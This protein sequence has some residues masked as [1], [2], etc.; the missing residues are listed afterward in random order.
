[1]ITMSARQ[2]TVTPSPRTRSAITNRSRIH[3]NGDERSAGARRFRDLVAAFS[4]DLGD[5]LSEADMAMIRTAA[6][7]TLKSE[8]MQAALIAGQAI[9]SDVLIRL[10]STSRRA[11]AAV[12]A[13][14]INRQ[15]GG[16]TLQD[17]LARRAAPD[18]G[19]E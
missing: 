5:N 3:Q 2:P 9:D 6:A 12:S 11:L 19:E 16:A 15:P 7:L 13:K 4:A 14:A 17:Y 10:A 18:D 1:V 8:Q